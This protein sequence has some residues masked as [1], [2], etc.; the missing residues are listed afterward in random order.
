M[1][2]IADLWLPILVA[3]VFVFLASSV[4]H[5]MIP[6]HKADYDGLDNED[7]VLAAMREHGVKP[8]NYALP[9]CRSMK[10]MASEGMMK[11]YEQGPVG[12]MTIIPSGPPAM[13][14]SLIQ[15][16]VF[17]IVMGICVA[18]VA[19][20]TLTRGQDYMDVFRLT[21]TVAFL[22][23]AGCVCTGSIWKGDKWSTSFKFVFDGLVYALATAG[24]FGWLWP[25]I[26]G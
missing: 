2:S 22:G 7:Q 17:C 18:Y 13:G 24:A 21:G 12:F 9:Y 6:I 1:L 11:K 5:M 25:G 14:K 26:A 10:D 8:G 19:T 4:I 23:Y 20:F 15:W 16:F 3:A